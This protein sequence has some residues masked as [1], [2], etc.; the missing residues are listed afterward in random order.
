MIFFPPAYI[1]QPTITLIKN[2]GNLFNLKKQH[3]HTPYSLKRVATGDNIRMCRI[4]SY[5][6]FQ[7]GKITL[8]QKTITAIYSCTA[9]Y[10]GRP[11]L[12]N[13]RKIIP[14]S[15][16]CREAGSEMRRST[17]TTYRAWT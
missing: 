2:Q 7:K 3:L 1:F 5:G 11:Y 8:I 10:A 16:A 6:F 13:S 15:Y 17:T 14:R 9:T 4:C 12:L